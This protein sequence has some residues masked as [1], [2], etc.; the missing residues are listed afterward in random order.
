MP[1]SRL[2]YSPLRYCQ[3]WHCRALI[4]F[5]SLQYGKKELSLPLN[6]DNFRR[7]LRGY[8]YYAPSVYLWRQRRWACRWR[9]TTK[10][11]FQSEGVLQ[12]WRL[13][14]AWSSKVYLFSL[15]D[16][17]STVQKI[18]NNINRQHLCVWNRSKAWRKPQ[19]QIK[20]IDEGHSS[21]GLLKQMFPVLYVL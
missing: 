10:G 1:C 6:D 19:N 21:R 16:L 18:L 17:Q 12:Y 8:V 15:V 3:L 13:R 20:V 5:R 7:T 2:W 14:Y 11:S 9:V 4:A